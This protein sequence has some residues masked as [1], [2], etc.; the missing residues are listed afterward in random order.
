MGRLREWID[1][2]I[3]EGKEETS[4]LASNDSVSINWIDPLSS[5]VKLNFDVVVR[6]AGSHP[7][8]IAQNEKGKILHVHAFK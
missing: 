2:Q 8:V 3:R 7:V 4:Q 1:A 5:T 6:G